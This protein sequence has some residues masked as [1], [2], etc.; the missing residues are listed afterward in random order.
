MKEI[1]EGIVPCWYVA[2]RLMGDFRI[3]VSP[4]PGLTPGP[5][6]MH[7]NLSYMNS[8]TLMTGMGREREISK[9]PTRAIGFL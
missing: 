4:V 3:R 1:D 9:E 7:L 8:V 5:A 6:M 2:R